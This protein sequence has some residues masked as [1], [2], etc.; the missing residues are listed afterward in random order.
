MNIFKH[1]RRNNDLIV[2]GAKCVIGKN[3]KG[4]EVYFLIARAHESYPVYGPA[5]QDALERNKRE[6]DAAEKRSKAEH[7]KLRSDI[8]LKVFA[9]NC[10]KGW[11]NVEG[12]DG[13]LLEY[14]EENI[15]KIYD[16]L[17][18]LIEELYKFGVDDSNYVGSFD[19]EESLKN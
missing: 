4:E 2:N 10:I 6:I 19:E 5:I 12:A 18:E 8:V 14:T 3:E 11:S 15:R 17:P 16:E 9:D 7:T 13:S 1:F